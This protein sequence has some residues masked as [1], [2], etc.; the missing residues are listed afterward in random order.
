MKKHF[1]LLFAVLTL[2]G[3]QAYAQIGY[4]AYQTVNGLK[5][6][7]KWAKAR[8]ESGA[9][10]PALLLAFENTNDF[11]VS[12][13]FDILLYYEGVLRENGRMEDLCLGALRSNMG[14]LNGIFFIPENFTE[15]QLKNSDFKF[16][17]DNLEVEKIEECTKDEEE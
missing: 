1:F 9:K 12:Y 3:I 16:E 4:T 7:T 2:T 6:S 17:I 5:V 8:D 11:P 15:D 10:K 14:K 13:S